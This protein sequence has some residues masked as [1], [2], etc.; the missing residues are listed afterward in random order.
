MKRPQEMTLAEIS[1]LRIVAPNAAEIMRATWF[2]DDDPM[3]Y[4]D[5]AG[6]IWRL[7]Q[8]AK[9]EWVRVKQNLA[10]PTVPL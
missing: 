8:T 2:D 10:A 6:G 3:S 4:A 1:L 7:H 5:A 9:G